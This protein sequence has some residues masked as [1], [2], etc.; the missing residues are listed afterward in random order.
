MNHRVL[1][2]PE[3]IKKTG[4]GR[5]N[6]YH[7]TKNGEFPA[8]VSLGAKAM[9]WIEAEIDTWIEKRMAARQSSP[10]A[11]TLST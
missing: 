8:S 6:L 2:L 10:E 3:V 1:R 11:S 5:T 9:G 4:L 7:M